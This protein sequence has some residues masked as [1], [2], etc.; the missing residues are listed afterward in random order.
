M[1]ELYSVLNRGR[2]KKKLISGAK[3]ICDGVPRE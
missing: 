1:E 3:R 2:K